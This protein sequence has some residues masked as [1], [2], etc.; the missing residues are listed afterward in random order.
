MLRSNYHM[1]LALRLLVIS[2]IFQVILC[3]TSI[4][5]ATTN[6]T[7]GQGFKILSGGVQDSQLGY[8]VQRAGDVNKDGI[9]D[10][11]FTSRYSTANS[12]PGAGTAFVIYGNATG[13]TQIDLNT[14]LDLSVGFKISGGAS[15]DMLGAASA[16]GDF[17]HDGVDDIIVGGSQVKFNNLNNAGSAYVIY[18]KQGGF[19]SDVDLST[20]T[21]S[22]GFQI[23]GP[24]SAKVGQCV[25]P[26]GDMNGDGIADVVISAIF[27]SFMSR[28]NAGAVYV[29]YGKQGGYSAN[30][31]LATLNST[32]GY[33]IVGA[34]ASDLFGY[35]LGPGRDLNGDNITDVLAGTYVGGA[36]YI[37]VI[38]GKQGGL[39]A[40]VDVANMAI[41]DGI[42]VTIGL[43]LGL[44]AIDAIDFDGDGLKDLIF[45][46][47]SY[48]RVYIIY[49]VLGGFTQ[50]YNF[51][52]TTFSTDVANILVSGISIGTALTCADVNGDG[53][54][55]IITG[56][57][58]N[59]GVIFGLSGK[60]AYTYS[61]FSSSGQ[62]ITFT[63]SDSTDLFGAST[64]AADINGDG[65]PDIIYG[66]INEDR[67]GI[68][69]VGS[70]FVIYS[71]KN[72]PILCLFIL[73]ECTV[74]NCKICKNA[75]KC[76]VCNTG[77][78]L[79]VTD[80][81]CYLNSNCPSTT[82]S[83]STYCLGKIYSEK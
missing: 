51:T 32:V 7:A 2:Q 82:Y 41:S 36:K 78:S 34:V 43:S 49:G 80:G 3:F 40:D 20:L 4:N 35:N 18:G 68:G 73:L 46:G 42:L 47:T 45:S 5:F 81:Q 8:D 44:N 48:G 83:N 39:T 10:F 66:S 26:G 27:A 63:P 72:D 25:R 59:A 54:G 62:L 67:N 14:T 6:L 58:N 11:I 22:Q 24:A 16:A 53:Y 12:R 71:S 70:V 15:Y 57:P 21:I 74:S 17:N 60:Q 75:L 76:I 29:I 23:G 19:T 61:T 52:S 9:D 65:L 33:K 1:K 55:D 38:W 79:Y 69:N 56:Q 77:Y 13:P 31:D 64:A 28:T 50:N 30:I 37:V